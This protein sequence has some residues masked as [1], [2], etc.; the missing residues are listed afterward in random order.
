MIKIGREPFDALFREAWPLLLRNHEETSSRKEH[1]L[2][3]NTGTYRLMEEAGLLRTYAARDQAG[4]L[5]GYAAMFIAPSIHHESLLQAAH[6]VVYV[7]PEYRGKCVGLRLIKYLEAD[8]LAEG[9]DEI[10]HSVK[11]DHPDFGV[12]LSKLGYEVDET[13][14]RKR[15]R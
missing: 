9:V 6:D 3:P 1:P 7:A 5:V 11:K 8:M 15:I 13:V 14:F 10:S 4:K 12:M 2:A